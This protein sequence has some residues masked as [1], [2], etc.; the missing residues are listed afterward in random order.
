MSPHLL[1]GDGKAIF[2]IDNK[3]HVR[4][5]CPYF[6]S[7]SQLTA[8]H[9]LRTTGVTVDNGAHV[10]ERNNG[11]LWMSFTQKEKQKFIVRREV[12]IKLI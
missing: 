7:P 6:K 10:T 9:R 8:R 5:C 12:I 3:N 4:T 1:L 11:T 2:E